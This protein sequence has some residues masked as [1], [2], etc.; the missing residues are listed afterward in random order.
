MKD[1]GKN[2]NNTKKLAKWGLM[3]NDKRCVV[4]LKHSILS[5]KKMIWYNDQVVK[6]MRGFLSGDF[7]YAWSSDK[8][9]FK[10]VIT[11]EKKEYIY[12]LYVDDTP[13]EDLPSF[14]DKD[15]I[16]TDDL[17]NRL[18]N[19]PIIAP[20]QPDEADEAEEVEEAEEAEEDVA[21]EEVE[22]EEENEFFSN[23][24]DIDD[25]WLD[26]GA[27]AQPIPEVPTEKQDD[28]AEIKKKRVQEYTAGLVDLNLGF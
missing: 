12:H 4:T 27:I 6:E 14:K 17:V 2:L 19:G 10:I 24:G 16:E 3:I 7:D 5:H 1:V 22:D 18:K 9:L 23:S 20:S 11:K 26:F 13:F 25:N 28:E 8:H 15:K 21:E